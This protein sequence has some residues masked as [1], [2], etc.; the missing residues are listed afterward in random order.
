MQPRSR[1]RSIRLPH[2]T[3]AERIEA[4]HRL[5]EEHDLRLV[6]ERLGQPDALDHALR[7]LPEP[8]PPLGAKAHIV[9]DAGDAGGE[10]R[11]AETEQAPEIAQQFL[12][13]EV[14]VE[15]GILGQEADALFHREIAHRAA[16]DA[17]RAGGGIEQLHQQLQR[18]ALAGAIRAEKSEHL[19]LVHRERE[20][21]Q[22]PIGSRPPEADEK[23]L[24]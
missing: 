2:L 3:A 23:I 10:I 12:G 9:E 11:P 20:A 16:Q 6:E 4:R 13:G 15:I 19:A 8:Q 21:V 22:G 14:I 17:G 5:V 1:S 18:G 24:G 7:I